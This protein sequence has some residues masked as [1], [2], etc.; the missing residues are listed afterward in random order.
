MP[1][2][3]ALRVA[4]RYARLHKFLLTI[5]PDM[6]LGAVLL[7]NGRLLIHP[8]TDPLKAVQYYVGL[9]EMKR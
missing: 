8:D 3:H 7:P 1:S 2:D 6:P 9:R 4:T 5:E